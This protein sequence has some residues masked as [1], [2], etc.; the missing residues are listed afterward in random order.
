MR[1]LARVLLGWGWK[2]TGSDLSPNT[3]GHLPAAGVRIHAGHAAGHLA[4]DTDQVVYSDAIDEKNPEL[5]RAAELGIPSLSYFEA[6]GR[7]SQDRHTLAVAGTHGKSTT[8]A[9]AGELLIEAGIDPTVVYGAEPLAGGRGGR[10]G[11]AGMMLVEACEY[12][13]N[14]LHLAVDHAVIL[15]IEAD[16]FD[17]YDSL[18]QVTK[19]FERFARAVSEDGLLIARA[20]CGAT[21]AAAATARCRVE[22]FGFEP[23]ADWQAQI[24][25]QRRGRYRFRICRRGH[26]LAEVRPAVPGRH[27]VV[28]ALAATA[29][30][31]HSGVDG[32]AIA[33]GLSRF[34]GLARRM[35]VVGSWRGV[36]LVSDYAHHPTEVAAGLDC[37]RRMYP[38]RRVWCV[39]QPHQASRTARLLDELA[40]SL[41]NADRI[42]V[43]EVYRAREPDG[44][45][46]EVTAADL[47][48]SVRALGVRTADVFDDEAIRELLACELRPGDVLIIM[49]AGDIWKIGHG[50]IHGLRKDRA[51]G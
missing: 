50:L 9:M 23:T 22:T 18:D 7:M 45:L 25:A 28:N 44:V 38:R 31:W 4:S 16:H 43:S 5:R 35:E 40:A 19:T 20:G 17:C 47:A 8:T 49:G 30:A 11:R 24:L 15:G 34:R 37:L 26:Q 42:V 3:L 12:R 10:A 46:G 41:Q 33:A 13:A 21:E 48:R 36:T 29:L 51:A 6:L 1:S 2:V 14:F 27:N 32:D 39:F